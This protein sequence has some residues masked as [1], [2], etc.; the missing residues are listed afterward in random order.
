MTAAV[1]P[2]IV[3]TLLVVLPN[4]TEVLV[5]V[6]GLRRDI[7]AFGEPVTGCKMIRTGAFVF[8]AAGFTEAPGY[9]AHDIAIAASRRP[10]PLANRVT[11]FENEI[12]TS[13]PRALALLRDS[14]P[15][16]LA[17]LPAG[18]RVLTA[19]FAAGD[20]N[21]VELSERAYAVVA[22]GALAVARSYERDLRSP[23]PQVGPRLFG[24]AAPA[25]KSALKSVRPPQPRNPVKAVDLLLRLGARV[26]ADSVG[27]PYEIAVVTPKA[28]KW[29][30]EASP[31]AV[32]R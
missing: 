32:P 10:G 30:P 15:R 25:V 2:F 16:G 6:D 20:G 9:S 24:D 3:G 8:A 17:V 22:D 23:F 27:P 4:N 31:C 14:M 1:G 12:L 28:V 18:R 13:L 5:G 26:K 11:W 29:F 7:A 21:N 19:V